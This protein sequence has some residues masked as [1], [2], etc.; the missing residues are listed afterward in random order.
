MQVFRFTGELWLWQAQ[1]SSA[2]VFVT[3]PTEISEEIREVVAMAGP[4]RGFGSVRVVATIGTTAWPTSIF[5]TKDRGSYLLPV[6]KA[7]RRA[8]DLEPGDV[9]SAELRMRL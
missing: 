3:V 1:T 4:P 9:V 8:E 6:K 7:V 2:W 5:P